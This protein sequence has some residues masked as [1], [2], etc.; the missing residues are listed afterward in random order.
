[1]T[2]TDTHMLVGILLVALL[3]FLGVALGLQTKS[4]IFPLVTFVVGLL[5][6]IIGIAQTIP[7]GGAGQYV[8]QGLHVVL[9]LAAIALAEVCASRYKRALPKTI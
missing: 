8:L 1:M 6:P 3:W 2:W 9:I 5:I 4:V 7:N